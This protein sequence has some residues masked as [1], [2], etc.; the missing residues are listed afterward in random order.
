[1]DYTRLDVPGS[2]TRSIV[3]TGLEEDTMYSIRMKCYN[4]ESQSDFS[5][6]AVK[7]TLGE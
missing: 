1:M 4:S 3:L 7:K 2:K 6:T 5:N